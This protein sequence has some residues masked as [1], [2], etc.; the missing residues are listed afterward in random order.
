M[1]KPEL[2]QIKES[3]I[4]KEFKE[5]INRGSVIDLAVGV[6]VGGAFSKIVSSLVADI[7][8]PIVGIIIGGVD[9]RHLSI[10]VPNFFGGATA[11]QITYGNFIQ[12]TI[13]FLAIAFCV[14]IFVRFMNKFQKKAK[15]E[16]KKEEDEQI[17]ILKEI[18]D[19]LVSKKS[20]TKK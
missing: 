14:F 17:K 18:R 4:L 13:D 8:M 3:V 7:L 5:F 19:S 6:I 11:A 9:F 10:V 20:P 1:K 16:T 15:E 2:P 12:S